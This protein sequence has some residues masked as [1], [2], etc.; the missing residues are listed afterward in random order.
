MNTGK[1]YMYWMYLPCAC[2][3]VLLLYSALSSPINVR[4]AGNNWKRSKIAVKLWRDPHELY[5]D[6]GLQ[7]FCSREIYILTATWKRELIQLSYIKFSLQVTRGGVAQW[8][9]HL[10]RNWW[11]PVSR[12]LRA[13][14]S[15]PL[16]PWARNFTL[17]V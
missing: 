14:Q 3:L 12:D 7:H 13:H 4:S 8:V 15:L 6:L 2:I 10:T 9:A 17:I 1:L 16:F 11:M 5:L